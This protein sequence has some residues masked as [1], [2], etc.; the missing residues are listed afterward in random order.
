MNTP[1]KIKMQPKNHQI[2]KETH[3]PNLPFWVSCFGCMAG[4]TFQGSAFFFVFAFRWEMAPEE[5]RGGFGQV[6]RIYCGNTVDG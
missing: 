4:I 6:Q 1:L 5:P 3:L 2:T